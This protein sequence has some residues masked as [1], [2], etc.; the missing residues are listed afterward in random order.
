V[1][2]FGVGVRVVG[3][4]VFVCECGYVEGIGCSVEYW[5]LCFFL[6]VVCSL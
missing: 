6:R 1:D 4:S 5:L 2:V 3:G